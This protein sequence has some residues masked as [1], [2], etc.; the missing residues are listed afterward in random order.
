[1]IFLCGMLIFCG[2]R[3]NVKR[4]FIELVISGIFVNAY[5]DDARVLHEITGYKFDKFKNSVG[6]PSKSLEKV[7][8]LIISNDVGYK[9]YEKHDLILEVNGN[10]KSYK[11]LLNKSIKKIAVEDRVNMIVRKLA[12]CNE[13]QLEEILEVVEDV[14]RS[15]E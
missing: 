3:K 14:L 6:F 4:D 9:I 5:G 2:W 1:M 11:K 7:K 15:E 13:E 12:N 10:E 8:N